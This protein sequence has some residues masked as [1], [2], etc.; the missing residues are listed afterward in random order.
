MYVVIGWN[1]VE[2]SIF[3]KKCVLIAKYCWVCR[4][5]RRYVLIWNLSPNFIRIS[6]WKDAL[7]H[8]RTSFEKHN[9]TVNLFLFSCQ[10][11]IIEL[12]LQ[13]HIILFNYIELRIKEK[14]K[15]LLIVL[16]HN[17]S[18][19][20]EWLENDRLIDLPNLQQI[21]HNIP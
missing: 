8:R 12:L 21:Y 19:V 11:S 2:L 20:M 13:L 18:G 3:L 1:K 16:I 6:V 5:Q 17:I 4:T 15:C 9:L 7:M 14:C 10:T